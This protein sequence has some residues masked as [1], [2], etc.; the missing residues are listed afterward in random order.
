LVLLVLCVHLGSIKYQEIGY[1]DDRYKL[2]SE[3]R[4]LS[5]KQREEFFNKTYATANHLLFFGTE[6]I[7]SH[8]NKDKT[9][10]DSLIIVGEFGEELKYGLRTDLCKKLSMGKTPYLFSFSDIAKEK[11]SQEL[12]DRLR[13]LDHSD[14]AEIMEGAKYSEEDKKIRITKSNEWIATLKIEEDLCYLEWERHKLEIGV[15]KK[16]DD[17]LNIYK[18]S[19]VCL[20]GDIGQYIVIEKD[21][22]KKVRCNF[23]ESFVR[24]NEIK[25]FSFIKHRVTRH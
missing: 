2:K 15:V 11:G 21:G 13:A 20:P 4:I 9:K 6:D 22:T 14:L 5:S 12:L 8:Y 7:I 19:M 23:C 16:E 25:T 10:E 17:K 1:N 18:K 3:P 24:P